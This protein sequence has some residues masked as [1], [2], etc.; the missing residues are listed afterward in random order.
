MSKRRS[1]E[2]GTTTVIADAS[3]EQTAVLDSHQLP[4][5]KE[6]LEKYFADRFVKWYNEDLP[7]GLINKIGSALFHVG[8][9]RSS[10][11]AMR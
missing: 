1:G 5:N 2:I 6:E 10:L 11:P 3:G 9:L 8:S 7:L 4:T